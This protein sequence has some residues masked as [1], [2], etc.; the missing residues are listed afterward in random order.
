VAVDADI[1]ALE[2]SGVYRGHYFVLGNLISLASDKSSLLRMPELKRRIDGLKP[3]EVIIALPANPE[4]DITAARIRE[5]IVLHAP[6]IQISMLG[7]G[8]ST[9][10]ELEYADPDT[11]KY[12][13]SNRK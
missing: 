8:L 6:V 5:E 13:L 1:E 11:L 4:G 7:R 12:A 3:I 9:G 10:S 2:R